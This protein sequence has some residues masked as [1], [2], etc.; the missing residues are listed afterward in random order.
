[1]G[2]LASTVTILLTL[3]PGA[4]GPIPSKTL[5]SEP[6]PLPA[7]SSARAEGL[8]S[9]AMRSSPAEAGEPLSFESK[10]PS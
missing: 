4:I 10:L 9:S 2:E 6:V 1:M 7:N 3:A 5:P 8:P